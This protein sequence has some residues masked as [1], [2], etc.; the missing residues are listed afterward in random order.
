[1]I[2]AAIVGASAAL[3]VAN[4]CSAWLDVAALSAGG[5]GEGSE[6]AGEGD[7]APSSEAQ[8]PDTIG[9]GSG[10]DGPLVITDTRVINAYAPLAEDVAVGA[11]VLPVDEPSAFAEGDRLLVWQS[12][13]IDGRPAVAAVDLAAATPSVG[14]YEFVQVIA[15]EGRGLRVQ[16]PVARAYAAAGAQI[17]KVPEHTDVTV[18]GSGVLAAAPWDGRSGGI[19]ALFVQGT[20]TVE[21]ELTADAVGFRGGLGS[22]TVFFR[23]CAADDG[24][25]SEGYASK[26]E[27]IAPAGYAASLDAGVMAGGR[28]RVANGGGGGNCHNAGGGG[29]GNGSAGGNGGRDYHDTGDVG[30]RGGAP[31]TYALVG[32]MAVGGGGGAP[33]RDSAI[34]PIH[35]ASGGGVIYAHA[36]SLVVTGDVRARG[37]S[38]AS[39][40]DDGAGGGGAGGSI[41]LRVLEGA[42]CS[43]PI[44]ARGGNGGDTRLIVIESGVHGPGGGGGG[45]RILLQAGSSECTLDAFSGVAGQGDR[46]G[47]AELGPT[48]GAT[49]TMPL[50]GVIE[51]P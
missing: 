13:G 5:G 42:R 24:S 43:R 8:A 16:P 39:V 37:G 12:T 3:A 34:V 22:P 41:V 1:M 14:H 47:G 46:D 50:P 10:K 30:G 44:V 2:L 21:G 6:D 49:P 20:L 4:G 38:V 40:A 33:E 19:I 48:Y 18:R 9:L 17:V 32:R 28:G 26:G 23:D 31:P 29:G 45:G 35:G 7:G 36:R 51:E 25:P 15:A 11:S 27:G